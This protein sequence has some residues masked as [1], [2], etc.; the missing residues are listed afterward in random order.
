MKNPK[1]SNLFRGRRVLCDGLGTF[2]NSVLCEFTGEN[3]SDAD[4]I[5]QYDLAVTGV[6]ENLRGLDLSG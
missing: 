6:G 4:V 5:C 2:R 1:E 3:E